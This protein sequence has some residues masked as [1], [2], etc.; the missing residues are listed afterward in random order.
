MFQSA[1]HV[2]N[3]D[4]ALSLK[5]FLVSILGGLACS[6]GL[7]RGNKATVN[8]DNNMLILFLKPSRNQ[9]VHFSFLFDQD[10]LKGNHV[11]EENKNLSPPFFIHLLSISQYNQDKAIVDSGTTLLRLPVN[12]FS[13]VVEAIS[14]TSLVCQPLCP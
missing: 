4:L 7:E 6:A 5:L 1:Q 8:K 2:R 12:V 14:R 10:L 9:G 3:K 11:T 13:A